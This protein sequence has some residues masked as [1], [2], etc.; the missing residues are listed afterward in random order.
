V[1]ERS[2]SSAVPQ[3]IQIQGAESFVYEQIGGA[4]LRLHVIYPPYHGKS[5]R[6]A[7]IVFFFG[8]AWVVGT[9]KQFVP[10]AQ[11]LAQ[12]GMVAIVADYRVKCRH[13]STPEDA[14]ADARRA[15]R[16]IRS[17]ATVLGIDPN[18][19][20]ASGGSAGGHLA[21]STALFDG[22]ETSTEDRDTSSKPNA[23]ILFNPWLG[24]AVPA[25]K[26]FLPDDYHAMAPIEHMRNDLPPTLILQGRAD[27][28]TP[29][30][31]AVHYC[32][33]ARS[34]GGKCEVVGYDG[35]EHGFFNAPDFDS[36]N[37]AGNPGKA[38]QTDFYRQTLFKA[39][40][41]LSSLEYFSIKGN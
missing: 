15:M 21:V 37:N 32:E 14:M 20:V 23:L 30:A 5:D 7:A 10:Q 33:E 13:G 2:P 36:P 38:I 4:S 17:H 24:V 18:R 34:K 16:W 9:V 8:G 29:Y 40:Q 3:P 11:Y 27:T 26:A 6:R 41:F 19:L 12:R 1:A 39:D 35:A 28:T 25:D 31:G 22:T